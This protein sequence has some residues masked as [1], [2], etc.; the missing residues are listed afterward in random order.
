[1]R[2][3]ANR[4]AKS[5]DSIVA[6]RADSDFS[7]LLAALTGKGSDEDGPFQSQSEAIYQALYEMANR[8]GIKTP[9]GGRY[10]TL[11]DFHLTELAAGLL[12]NLK[13]LNNDTQSRRRQT[14]RL[15][16]FAG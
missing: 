16:K 1:M 11:S 6:V 10:E 15:T 13:K 14:V 7:H 9:L 3:K 5:P 12:V 8:M 4:L 2:N